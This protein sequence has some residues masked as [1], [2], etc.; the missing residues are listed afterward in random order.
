MNENEF[1]SRATVTGGIAKA[2]VRIAW[3][4][5]RFSSFSNAGLRF[6]ATVDLGKIM[7]EISRRLPAAR[8]DSAD[9]KNISLGYNSI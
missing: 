6:A 5:D 1:D 2:R 4:D 7:V 8:F 3:P 9:G